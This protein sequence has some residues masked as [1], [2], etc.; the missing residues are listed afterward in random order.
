[1]KKFLI[2]FTAATIL[3]AAPLLAQ[4][5]TEPPKLVGLTV[6]PSTVDVSAAKQTAN[7]AA[8]VTDNLSGIAA[9]TVDLRSP[10]GQRAFGYAPFQS[11]KVLDGN[12]NVPVEI[13]RYAEPGAWSVTCF[14]YDN[15]YN[16]AVIDAAALASAG[17]PSTINVIDSN[18]DLQAPQLA[19]VLLNPNSVNVSA[20]DATIT[21]DLTI[22]DNVA[23][24][25][26]IEP[27]FDFELQSPSGKQSRLR[28]FFDFVRISG[29]ANNGVYRASL[30]MPR[31]SEPGIWKVVLVRV[32]D[33]ARNERF[34]FQDSLA[35]FAS[36]INVTVASSPADVTLPQLTGLTFTPTF[37]NTSTGSQ[38]VQ[39]DFSMTDDLSGVSFEPDT[40][41][42]TLT[43]GSGFVSPSGA[44]R[45]YTDFSFQE[46]PPIIGTRLNGV[47]RFNVRFPQFSEEGTWKVAFLQLR[48]V[49]R[50][51]LALGSP[52]DVAALG[53]PTELTVIKPSLV[54]DGTI[55]N[56]AAGGTVQDDTFGDRAKVIVPP[57]VLSDA[58]TIAIDVLQSPISV[59]LPTGFSSAETYFVNVQLIPTPVFPLP[60]PGMSV[61]L[62]LRNFVAPGTRINLFFID[63]ATGKLVPS[64]DASGNPV[65][66]IVDP[67]GLSATFTGI[68]HFSTI[69]GILPDVIPIDVDIKPGDTPN[70]INTRSN[71][72]IPVAL[73]STP[74]LDLTKVDPATIHMAGAP[75]ASNKQGKFQVSTV[76]VN[77][78]GRPDIIVH[79]DTRNLQLTTSSVRAVVEG[80]T[81]DGRTFSGSDSVLVIK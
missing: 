67:S 21:V 49:V 6:T 37:I 64:L 27:Q 62:P 71:G 63:T 46:K 58:T 2:A 41:V 53:F 40:S 70:V 45:T 1:M 81:R 51:Y 17:F 60:P 30:K 8:H 33:N 16:N 66:G 4:S 38:T 35:A 72:T 12:F 34:Y 73:M 3:S 19:G 54:P 11:G 77:G 23:G 44:Q 80:K 9:V 52:Q 76:D 57:G 55:T 14:L 28:S 10:S 65:V 69:V 24:V 18:P 78:D 48:D 61:V 20:D 56:P 42:I 29:D 50:N 13:P 15:V 43:W 79:F 25:G 75:I 47:W 7:F 36:A 26:T 31:Y 74:T 5:D 68:T 59:D 22:T 39:M 32:E